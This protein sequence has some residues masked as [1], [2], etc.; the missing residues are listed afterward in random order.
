MKT[1]CYCCAI[2]VHQT[3]FIL[4]CTSS[5]MPGTEGLLHIQL[6]RPLKI[7]MAGQW[8]ETEHIQLPH[9]HVCN[10]CLFVVLSVPHIRHIY[11]GQRKCGCRAEQYDTFSCSS[12]SQ[13]CFVSA[14]IN[15]W[16]QQ[17]WP[18]LWAGTS[19]SHKCSNPFIVPPHQ[20]MLVMFSKALQWFLSTRCIRL[21][22]CF[23]DSCVVV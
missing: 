9:S 5:L 2:E 17:I 23:I 18:K 4:Y 10:C 13:N 12:L 8:F 16:Q 19:S 1:L 22:H 6:Q 7:T 11:G 15:P 21:V 3:K 20:W 14:A